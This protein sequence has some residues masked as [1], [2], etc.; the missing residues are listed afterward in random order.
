MSKM[1]TEERGLESGQR[2]HGHVAVVTGAASGIGRAVARRLAAE[3]AAVA[4]IDLADG[5]GTVRDIASAHGT[6]AP[7]VVDVSDP[8]Q[9]AGVVAPIE[10]A[11]GP[12]DIV[13]NNAG[14]YPRIML[15]DLTLEQWRHVFAVNVESMLATI[16]AFTPAM[17]NQGWGRIVNVSSN[18]IGMR[19]PGVAHYV[20]SKMAVIG[21]TRAAATE[22][23]DFGITANAIAPSVTRTPGAS[24]MPDEGFAALAQLQTIKRTEVP[25]DLTGTVAFL[26]SDDAAFMTGQTLY[27]DG[28]LIRSS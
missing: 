15:E 5:S 23:A 27:V 3:G 25:E 24:G 1:S 11:F 14:I 19:V 28:G 6:A 8:G 16:Q 13:V 7:F 12:V 4:V 22:L 26:A 10:A 20:A 9:V 2:L 17:K 21:L 18:S